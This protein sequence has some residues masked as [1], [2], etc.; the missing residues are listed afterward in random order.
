MRSLFACA[1]WLAA[2]L[3]LAAVGASFWRAFL[4]G[5]SARL[6]ALL[7]GAP[8]IATPTGFTLPIAPLA[9]DVT[10]ACSGAGFFLLLVALTGAARIHGPH[11]RHVLRFVRALPLVYALAVT[12]NACRIVAGWH[13]GRAAR[14][15]LPAHYHSGV[16]LYTGAIVFFVFLVGFNLILKGDAKWISTLKKELS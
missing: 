8:C 1:V 6:A 13:A 2:L 12:A 9:V 5:P 15:L 14:V 10:A 11:V 4:T 16:H 3:P 7:T